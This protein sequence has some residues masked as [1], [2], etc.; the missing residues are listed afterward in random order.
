MGM[1]SGWCRLYC[2]PRAQYWSTIL[3][4]WYGV[5]EALLQV[6]LMRAIWSSHADLSSS[7]PH[8]LIV[9][10]LI[11]WAPPPQV[12]GSTLIISLRVLLVVPPFPYRFQVPVK[13]V[14]TLQPFSVP[15][16]LVSWA[17]VLNMQCLHHAQ[18]GQDVSKYAKLEY[19]TIT[20]A[21]CSR[22]TRAISR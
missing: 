16:S 14:P 7:G 6:L 8:K 12:G 1:D 17:T 21:P 18:M 19:P 2:Q 20:F 11:H 3:E 15:A 22:R 4:L 9:L 5:L 13:L 10:S